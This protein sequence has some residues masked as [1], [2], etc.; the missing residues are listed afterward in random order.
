LTAFFFD[1]DIGTAVPR[2]LQIV[3]QA[4][5][6]VRYHDELFDPA[7]DD[8]EWIRDV[9]QRGWVVITRNKKIGTNPAEV[10]AV[11]SANL[12]CFCLMQSRRFQLDRWRTLERV[13]KSWEDMQAEL[14]V[15]P[16]PFFVGIRGD[17]S[18]KVIL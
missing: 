16:A 7:T 18:F 17:G 9:G 14:Q 11:R 2:A 8:V 10:S 1:R 13:V 4:Y 5:D 6:D 15:R 12:R 3:R